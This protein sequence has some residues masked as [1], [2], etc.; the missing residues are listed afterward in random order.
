MNPSIRPDNNYRSYSGNDSIPN[1]LDLTDAASDTTI[2]TFLKLSDG[3]HDQNV[4]NLKIPGGIETAV[5]MDWATNVFIHGDFGMGPNLSDNVL[6]AKGPFKNIGFRGMLHQYGQRN[7]IDIELGN[8]FDQA[9]GMGSGCDLRGIDG[10]Q[11]G[12]KVTLAIGWVVPFT[13]KYNPD[14]VKYLVWE[15]LKLKAYVALKHL[16]RWVMRIP[17][18]VK[19]PSWL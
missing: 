16:V 6:R 18:G 9:P 5:D 7:G 11:N 15:S 8:H 12:D 13:V 4:E 10:H 17:A 14:Y 3:I 2:S 1:G 19:G